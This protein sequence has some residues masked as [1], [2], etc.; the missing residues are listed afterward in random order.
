[1]VAAQGKPSL[2]ADEYFKAG[3]VALDAQ[4]ELETANAGS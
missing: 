4:Y 3:T 2:S 1:V